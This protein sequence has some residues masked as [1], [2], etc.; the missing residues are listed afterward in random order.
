MKKNIGSAFI[1]GPI[2]K[3]HLFGKKFIG[4][5]EYLAHKTNSINKEA[6]LIYNKNLSVSPVTTH[7]PLKMVSKKITQKKTKLI[8][9]QKK[10][11]DQPA[12]I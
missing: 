5:T 8:K 4:V 6:M 10:P 9:H 1:N 3:K 11:I 12:G 2:S 7:I